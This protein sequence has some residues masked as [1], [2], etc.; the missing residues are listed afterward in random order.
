ML[1][2]GHLSSPMPPGQGHGTTTMFPTWRL[3]MNAS[4]AVRS[5][6]NCEAELAAEIDSILGVEQAAALIAE[7]EVWVSRSW[8]SRRPRDTPPRLAP[9]SDQSPSNNAIATPSIIVNTLRRCGRG[10][11]RRSAS[12][13]RAGTPR[14]AGTSGSSNRR[15]PRDCGLAQGLLRTRRPHRRG[16]SQDAC[17]NDQ[18]SRR[19]PIRVPAA[20]R[21]TPE[22]QMDPKGGLDLGARQRTRS[23][24]TRVSSARRRLHQ[25]RA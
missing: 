15:G 3:S 10:P 2:G 16:H 1:T 24:W 25:L 22:N 23:G 7:K 18:N 13:W 5:S 6:E 20:R 19:C 17:P 12:P 14:S 21:R 11:A 9:I 8:V 4:C